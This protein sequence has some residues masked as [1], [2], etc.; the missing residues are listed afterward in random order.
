MG[1]TPLC[2]RPIWARGESAVNQGFTADAGLLFAPTVAWQIARVKGSI[3]PEGL[4][5]FHPRIDVD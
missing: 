5:G 1:N 4:P 3:C 2:S